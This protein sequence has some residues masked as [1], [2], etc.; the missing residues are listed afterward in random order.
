MDHPENEA[1]SQASNP[2]D[3]TPQASE[4]HKGSSPHFKLRDGLVSV[5]VFAKSNGKHVNLFVVP[6]RSYKDAK[7][8]WHRTHLMH[9]EDL[10]RLSFLLIRTYAHL[11][12]KSQEFT[13]DN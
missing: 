13:S 9:E 1:N 2:T 7:G 8:N 6:E 10:L 12:H 11:R 3:E 4:G 5:T